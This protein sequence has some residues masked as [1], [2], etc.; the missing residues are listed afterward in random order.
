[1]K[2][3]ERCATTLKLPVS[4]SAHYCKNETEKGRRHSGAKPVHN[5]SLLEGKTKVM[6]TIPFKKVAFFLL[7]RSTSLEKVLGRPDCG[8]SALQRGP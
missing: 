1:M 8:I 4:R 7:Q 6:G 2:S 5:I 3:Q